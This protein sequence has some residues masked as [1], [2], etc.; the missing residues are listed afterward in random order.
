MPQ[1]ITDTAANPRARLVLA[2]GAGAPMD[3]PFMHTIAAFLAQKAV[4]VRRFEFPYMQERRKTGSKRPPNR[5]NDL[6]ACW[7]SVLEE[8]PRDLPLFIGGKSL[9]G[10]MASLI[11]DRHRDLRGLVC[12]GYPFHPAGKPERLRVEHLLTMNTPTL[13]VQGERDTLGDSAE[14]S[15]YA[16]PATI[17]LVWLPDGDHSFKPRKKSGAT[18]EGNM[19]RAADAVAAFIASRQTTLGS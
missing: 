17:K 8:T 15:G 3:S 2:H 9:G 11:A 14:V 12:L 5:Q 18:L 7:E 1:I 13:I 10:R 19:Q 4:E 6:L 16:L